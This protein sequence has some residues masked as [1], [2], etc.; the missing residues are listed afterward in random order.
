MSMMVGG[1]SC[2]VARSSHFSHAAKMN[3]ELLQ[4]FRDCP[5]LPSLPAVAMQVLELTRKADVD[6]T[7]IARVI[8]KDPAISSRIL[9]TVNSSFYARS[10]NVG[11]ISNAMVIMGLQSVKTLVLGFSLV[12]NLSKEKDTPTGFKHLKYWKRSITAA[13]AVRVLGA[14]LRVVQQE[15]V[16]LI[17]LLMDIGVLIMDQVLG[18]QYGAVIATVPSHEL[19]S[20]AEQLGLELDHAQVGGWIAEQWKLPPILQSTIAH[21]HDPSAVA[22]PALR[23]LT[24]LVCLAGRCADVFVDEQ[25][26]PAIGDV[27]HRMAALHEWTEADCDAILTEIGS[28]TKE[29]ATLFDINI[30]PQASY[31]ATLKRA[32]ETLVEITLQSQMQV[33]QLSQQNLQLKRAAST[34]ALTGLVNRGQLDAVLADRFNTAVARREFL[35]LLM[36]DVD[37]FKL[38]NDEHGHPAG[39]AV[40]RELG[41]ILRAV[42]GERGT[43]ARYGGEEMCLVLP[44]T[45]RP[46]AAA[47]AGETSPGHRLRPDRG[48][49]EPHAAGDGEHRRGVLRTRVHVP[50]R[51]QPGKGRRPWR[52]RRQAGG[53]ELRPRAD[54]PANPFAAG[55]EASATAESGL[56]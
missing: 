44:G 53:T 24:E 37:K 47:L 34:D 7:E 38:V 15:E 33:S 48:G 2:S 12:S 20:A 19:Q 11:T 18:Q 40:L 17:A 56:S 54:P 4:K 13:T 35:S 21:H 55:C 1:D 50:A 51:E 28:R 23:K 25:P 5:N 22:D 6:L 43:A 32:S 36:L 49:Q 8:T 46:A 10:Q 39:D 16:F 31:D 9:K 3:A 42:V 41:R 29:V 30:G 14:K 26:M 45:H 27:R 52:L